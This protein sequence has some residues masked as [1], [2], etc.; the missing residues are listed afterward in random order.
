MSEAL[1]NGSDSDG[2]NSGGGGGGGD[3]RDIEGSRKEKEA[4]KAN[5]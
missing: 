4:A 3:G 5:Q 1:D 2:G